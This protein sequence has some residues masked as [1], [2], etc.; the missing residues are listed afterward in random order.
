MKKFMDDDFLLQTDT[1]KKLYHE[2]AEKMPI[3]DFHNHLNPKEIYDDGNYENITK[4]WLGGDHYKWRAMRTH[5]IP[6]ELITGDAPDYDKF[7]AWAETV[8]NAIGNPL[9]HWTH[10]E[11]KRYFDI[12]KPFNPDTAEEIW[13]EVNEKLQKPEYSVRNLLRKMNVEVLCT[14]D[15]P[16]DDLAWH[17]KL[18]ADDS[19]AIKVLPTFRPDRAIAMEKEDFNDY[20]DQLSKAAAMDI[21]TVD[22]LMAALTARLDYFVENGAAASDHSLEYNIY[23]DASPEEV[24]AI[25]RKR[26]NNE[27]LT[28]EEYSKYRGFMLSRLGREYAKRNMAMQLHIGAQ[29]NNSERMFKKLGAD[30]G[31]DSMSDMNYS[32]EIAGLLNNMD[33]TDELPKTVLY[34]ANPKDNEMLATMAVNFNNDKARGKVQFGP[35]W[36]FMDHKPGMER[37]LDALASESL[38]SGFIGM[39]TDSRSFLSF[40]RHEYFRRILS[41][42]I[43]GWVE[44]GEYPD[45]EKYLGKLVEDIAHDNAKNYF[46]V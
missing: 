9:Y 12:D 29:R 14:T 39:L 26:R 45:D 16:I 46:G 42:K 43:G 38:I 35:A 40:P 30:T 27:E 36:W 44:N 28:P 6:E 21:E 8:Q 13:N 24:E 20:I 23:Q 41:N 3:I 10:L 31:Y 25:F 5:G 11:L 32:E 22:D 18:K 33:K 37:Q 15:D 17:K 4:L 19:F 1:A 2:H 7:M 34:N